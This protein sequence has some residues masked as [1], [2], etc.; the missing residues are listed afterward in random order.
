MI[1]RPV[2]V[3]LAALLLSGAGA[4][5]SPAAPPTRSFTLEVVALPCP[6]G[7]GPADGICLAY[8]GQIPGPALVVDALDRLEIVLVNHV[9]QTVWS[10]PGPADVKA[11]L[12]NQS[13]S[14]HVHGTALAVSQDGMSHAMEPRFPDSFAP[15]GG[16]FTYRMRAAYNGTWHFHDHVLGADGNEGIARGLA[17]TLIVRS[18]A[19]I[20]PDALVDVHATSGAPFVSA[21]AATVA[22]G[23]S[24]ELVFVVLGDYPWTLELSGPGVSRALTQG[25]GESDHLIVAHA[26]GSYHWTLTN[27]LLGD[28]YEGTVSAS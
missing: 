26:A 15:P 6:A 5:V 19:E 4:G 16:S 17:G 20:R 2:L 11:A 28:T 13:V 25:P 3:A 22:A 14:F 23:G 24:F 9:P 10:V 27:A 7:V 8:N 18:G 12:A 21:S 1:S